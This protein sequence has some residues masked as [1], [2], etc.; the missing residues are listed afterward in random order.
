MNRLLADNLAG[1]EIKAAVYQYK[2]LMALYPRS[3]YVADASVAVA[4]ISQSRL[5]RP[6]EAIAIY[7]KVVKNYPKRAAARRAYLNMATTY[8][9]HLR[10]DAKAIES[11]KKLVRKYPRTKE[12]STGN[13]ALARLYERS[14]QYKAAIDANR[15]M[16]KVSRDSEAI[17]S[18]LEKAAF[19]AKGKL[20]N[21]Q[22]MIEIDRQLCRNYPAHDA[23]AKARYRSGQ[24]YEKQLHDKK[25]AV[26]EYKKVIA[27]FPDHRLAKK[28]NSRVKTLQKGGSGL[29]LF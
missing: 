15:N 5:S 6:K 10:K 1:K 26:S 20:K 29:N 4:D 16:L 18:S 11:L 27:K 17:V 2:T 24:A 12:A 13:Q 3:S 22:V 9:R 21:Y 25:K 7:Q 19:I 28:A 8:E 23:C 14:K